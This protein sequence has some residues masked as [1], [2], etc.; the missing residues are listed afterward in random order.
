MVLMQ[1]SQFV[2]SWA[3]WVHAFY[4]TK[5]S[6]S[7]P[8]SLI[9]IYTYYV[10]GSSKTWNNLRGISSH[11]QNLSCSGIRVLI[12]WKAGTEYGIWAVVL[13]VH[14]DQMY[15]FIHRLMNNEKPSIL[16]QL[17][18]VFIVDHALLLLLNT[19]RS[20]QYSK[21]TFV[22]IGWF[23]EIGMWRQNN[24]ICHFMQI[25][26]QNTST[27]S[28]R[29]VIFTNVQSVQIYVQLYNKKA[30]FQKHKRNPIQTSK[31]KPSFHAQK[32]TQFK[33]Q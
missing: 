4:M 2:Q 22:G 1:S 23:F 15:E 26:S 29:C 17:Y 30:D 25:R 3:F 31:Y 18:V 5:N 14:W 9:C 19:L 12:C 8:I 21:Y 33:P 32:E 16:R 20:L 24:F 27:F 6:A 13:C 7:N 10:H 28:P 11:K